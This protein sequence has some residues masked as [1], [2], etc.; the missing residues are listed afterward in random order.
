MDRHHGA[1]DRGG[2]A[3]TRRRAGPGP[4]N[5]RPRAQALLRQPRGR[6]HGRAAPARAR[7][8]G[9]CA[10]VP[11]CATVSAAPGC[12][13]STRSPAR[14]ARCSSST[15]RSPAPRRGA[16]R[17]ARSYLRA[18]PRARAVAATSTPSLAKRVDAPRG[19][20]ILRYRQAYRGIPA[21]DSGV[22]VALDRAG[23]VL[24]VTGSPQRGPGGRLGDAEADAAAALRALQR[25]VGARAHA[26]GAAAP[27]ARA[28]RRA[29]RA[30][31][32]R[33]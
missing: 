32:R 21:F 26:R 16:R 23:R 13:T 12:S 19:V 4:G 27:P 29:S 7:P 10:S 14:R 2:A 3:R 6:R 9:S 31:S 8:R 28:G 33:G 25:S 20:T 17:I 11:L 18:K 24:G 22:R 15:A 30:A 5:R 1:P